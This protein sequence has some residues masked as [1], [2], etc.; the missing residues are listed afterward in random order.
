MLF[1]V[2]DDMQFVVGGATQL[3]V[4]SSIDYYGPDSRRVFVQGR[5]R[6]LHD[7]TNLVYSILLLRAHFGEQTHVQ[8]YIVY[9]F[10]I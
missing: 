4:Y 5:A 9:M 8:I 6:A 10:L 2:V 3:L 1:N 7:A